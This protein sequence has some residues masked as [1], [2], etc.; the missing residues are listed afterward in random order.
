MSS[1][2]N[3]NVEAR[4]ILDNENI[5]ERFVCSKAEKQPKLGKLLLNNNMHLTNLQQIRC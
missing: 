1:S 3:Q 2:S 5:F 4:I